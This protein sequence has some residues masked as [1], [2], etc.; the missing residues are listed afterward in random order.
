[1]L[2]SVPMRDKVQFLTNG[3]LKLLENMFVK[4]STFRIVLAYVT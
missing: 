1:M 3:S 4:M 2:Y